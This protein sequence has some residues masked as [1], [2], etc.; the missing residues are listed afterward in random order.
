MDPQKDILIRVEAFLVEH[1]MVPTTFGKL[2][3]NDGSFVSRLRAGVDMKVS[4]LRR[5]V[6][7]MEATAGSDAA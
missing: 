7:F 3:V 4:T 1:K 6:A 2:A 5:A